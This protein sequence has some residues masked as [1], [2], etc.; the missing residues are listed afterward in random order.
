MA[1]VDVVCLVLIEPRNV[2]SDDEYSFD[3]CV[4]IAGIAEDGTGCC[5]GDGVPLLEVFV[6]AVPEICSGINTCATE[7]RSLMEVG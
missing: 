6:V 7:N 2:S 5:T 4:S 1:C 3:S